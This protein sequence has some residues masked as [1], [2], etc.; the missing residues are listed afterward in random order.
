MRIIDMHCDVLMKLLLDPKA[1]FTE[2]HSLDVSFPSLVKGRSKLQ[3]FAIY[4]PEH[5]PP[6]SRFKAAVSMVYKLQD[7]I[8]SMP[9]IKLV[10]NKED[11]KALKDDEIG[12]I[13]SLEGCDCLDEDLGQLRLLQSLGVTAAGITW[14]YANV[15]ADG[16]LEPRNG[17]LT[18]QGR[19]L[20]HYMKETDML[21]DVSHL[22]EAAFWDCLDLG[23]R[24]FASHSN[25]R[26]L[27][28]TTRNLYDS[29]I[30]AMI[31]RDSLIGITFVP[32]FLSEAEGATMDDIVR[33]IEH[34][35][36]LGGEKHI[37][38][39]SDFDG[40]DRHVSRLSN[41]SCYPDLLDHLLR[42]YSE[43]Q[44]MGFASGNYERIFLD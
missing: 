20:V 19:K 14:N 23:G 21:L 26:S 32:Q 28:E 9:S 34:I 27:C 31:E 40:I 11:Y 6:A 38:F 1:S 33:H 4:V 36:S 43:D 44:V 30:E 17:G 41:F 37:G 16:A 8:L 13:L 25:C 29:Q 2:E 3:Y 5:I 7:N 35:C 42:Y 18:L 15:F 10:V 22:S 12:V 24:L 39:G